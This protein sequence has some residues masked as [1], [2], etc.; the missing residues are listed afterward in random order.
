MNN[1][2]QSGVQNSVPRG[3]GHSSPS[4]PVPPSAER[5]SVIHVRNGTFPLLAVSGSLPPQ[6]NNRAPAFLNGSQGRG[7]VRGSGRCNLTP[8]R[9]S[10]F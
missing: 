6:Q 3:R 5:G 4:V 8:G 9:G 7:N 10:K 2:V 1:H